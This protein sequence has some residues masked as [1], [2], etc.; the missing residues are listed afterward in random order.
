[1]SFYYCQEANLLWADDGQT[2]HYTFREELPTTQDLV[3][4]R[5][6]DA[7]LSGLGPRIKKR[8]LSAGRNVNKMAS[9]RPE[10]FK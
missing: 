5:R 10:A 4:R 7:K 1:M 8:A 3:V 6:A 9:R 2:F